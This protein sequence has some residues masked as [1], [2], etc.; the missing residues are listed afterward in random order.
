LSLRHLLRLTRGVGAAAVARPE[1]SLLALRLGLGAGGLL[2]LDLRLA[3]L[4]D[5]WG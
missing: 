2:R 3:A 5:L 1:L 4:N